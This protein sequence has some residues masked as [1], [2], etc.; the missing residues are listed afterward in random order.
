MPG[1]VDLLGSFHCNQDVLKIDKAQGA[2]LIP[3]RRVNKAVCIF[4]SFYRYITT[5]LA[6]YLNKRTCQEFIKRFLFDKGVFEINVSHLSEN[7]R[8]I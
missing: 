7:V 2:I 1:Q 3:F 6:D 4:S 5:N 8:L